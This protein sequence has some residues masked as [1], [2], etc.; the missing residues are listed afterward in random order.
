MADID[1]INGYLE[2][3]DYIIGEF[4]EFDEKHLSFEFLLYDSSNTVKIVFKR[5]YYKSVQ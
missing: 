3:G 4:S 2:F 5:L 1:I